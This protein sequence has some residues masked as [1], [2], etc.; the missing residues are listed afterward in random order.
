MPFLPE[1][2]PNLHPLIVHFP[3]GILFTAA[4]LDVFGLVVKDRD[5]PRRA[6]MILYVLGGVA[7][8]AA[9]FT[10][11]AAAD[12]VFLPN[13]ANALLTEHSDLGHYTFYFFASF[14]VIRLITFFTGVE[15]TFLVRLIQTVLGLGGLAL[16]T[17]TADHGAQMVFQHG[18]GVAAVNASPVVAIP[19]ADSSAVGPQ[20]LENG[21]WAWRPTRASAWQQA[22]VVSGPF[23]SSLMDGGER[24]DV[25]ALTTTGEPAAF[26][27]EIPMTTV[28]IDAALDLTDFDGTVMLM[29]HV[30]DAENY[31]FMAVSKEDMRLGRSE[32]G[33]LYLM[34][35]KPYDATGWHSYRVVG[36]KTHFRAY[37]DA[38]LV[39]HGH[40]DDPGSGF[41]GVRLNGTGTVRMASIQ[42]LPV[43]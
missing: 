20:T 32:N 18:V 17:Y 42:V 7:A 10:G 30:I 16:L 43:R 23:P 13:A 41:V 5:F 2:A 22:A 39:T 12:S 33:D 24:G 26:W 19:V 29:H 35:N 1:W 36:D 8:T 4:L 27:F 37:S 40:G 11:E 31:H 25:L 34:D 14:A 21:G 6:A 3:I 28:Q 9:Y 15:K 38:A